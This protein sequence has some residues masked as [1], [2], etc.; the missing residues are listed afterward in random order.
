MTFVICPLAARRRYEP[1]ANPRKVI[2][3]RRQ[4]LMTVSFSHNL[5][6]FLLIFSVLVIASGSKFQDE[7]EETG[8]VRWP[9]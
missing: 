7:L 1:V 5:Q 6:L 2:C 8:L 4:L 3:R 9:G